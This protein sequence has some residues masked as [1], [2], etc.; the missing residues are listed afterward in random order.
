MKWWLKITWIKYKA[1]Y[2]NSSH[3]PEIWELHGSWGGNVFSED[4]QNLGVILSS[5]KPSIF[6]MSHW[7]Q[8]LDIRV[9][10]PTFPFDCFCAVWMKGLCDSW[11]QAC[12]ARSV[13]SRP[14]VPGGQVSKSMP[15]PPEDSAF[16]C[17]NLR[18]LDG[19]SPSQ[20][21]AQRSADVTQHN[22]GPLCSLIR[23][24][25]ILK[26]QLL[27]KVKLWNCQENRCIWNVFYKVR[28]PRVRQIYS[29]IWKP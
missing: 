19:T 8:A 28:W 21:D 10:W 18:G 11:G 16:S 17:I 25:D 3:G 6:Q 27:R 15:F 20:S 29:L 7:K 12:T 1:G 9:M 5:H 24:G 4:L 26:T 23:S 2:Y 22:L 13:G 14:E